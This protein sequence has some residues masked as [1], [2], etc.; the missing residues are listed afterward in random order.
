MKQDFP[1]W[2]KPL[3][4]SDAYNTGDIVSYKGDLYES[5][6]DHNEWSPEER[7]KGWVVVI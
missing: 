1:E 4:A 6:I 3:G 2:V 5:I 7:P